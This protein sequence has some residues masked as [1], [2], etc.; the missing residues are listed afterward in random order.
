[1]KIAMGMGFYD[2]NPEKFVRR[3]T[4]L[5]SA[6]VDVVWGGEIYGFDLGSSLAYLAAK[7]STIELMTGIFPVYSRAEELLPALEVAEAR[8]YIKA[9][10]APERTG[11]G[12][13]PSPRFAL[14]PPLEALLTESTERGPAA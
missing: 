9:L 3:V 2:G 14:R 10:P 8:G 5:E 11:P 13:S 12:R 7:T 4:D 1:M 6:G